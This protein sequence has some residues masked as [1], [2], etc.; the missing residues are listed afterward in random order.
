MCDEPKLSQKYF[1][2]HVWNGEPVEVL[3]VCVCVR[4]SA[5]VRVFRQHCGHLNDNMDNSINLTALA[6]EFHFILKKTLLL[7]ENVFILIDCAVEKTQYMALLLNTQ[8]RWLKKTWTDF[9]KPPPPKFID[10]RPDAVF[11][12][13]Y[14]SELLLSGFRRGTVAQLLTTSVLPVVSVFVMSVC[15]PWHPVSMATHFVVSVV[16]KTAL[17]P[18]LLI[19]TSSHRWFGGAQQLYLHMLKRQHKLTPALEEAA[20][21]WVQ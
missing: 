2:R 6:Y 1:S 8:Q 4:V 3:V 10:H 14:N 11:H 15:L 17:C 19:S 9:V 5:C 20:S 7:T 18:F 16:G 13:K 21:E 12:L